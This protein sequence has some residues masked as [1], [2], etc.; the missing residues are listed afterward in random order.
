MD[1]DNDYGQTHDYDEPDIGAREDDVSI[2]FL[3]Y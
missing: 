1:D 2:T 3:N